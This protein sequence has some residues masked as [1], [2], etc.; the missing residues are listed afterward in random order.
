VTQRS[1]KVQDNM[2]IIETFGLSRFFG[3]VA[4]LEDLTLAVEAGEVLGFL[5]P[6]GSGK[7][8]TSKLGIFLSSRAINKEV[9]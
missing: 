9:K 7:T 3:E 8:T 6:N 2:A 5:G 4:A 1:H